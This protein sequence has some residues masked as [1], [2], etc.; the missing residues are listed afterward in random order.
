MHRECP[1]ERRKGEERQRGKGERGI[2]RES[3]GRYRE[4]GK[5]EAEGE[6]RV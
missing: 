5:G 3:G 6:M 2:E 1:V 4:G